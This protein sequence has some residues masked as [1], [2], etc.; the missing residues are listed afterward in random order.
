MNLSIG[1]IDT[2]IILSYLLLT[3]YIGVKQSRKIHNLRDYAIADKN[4]PLPVLVA[5][6]S[7]TLI[8]GGSTIGIVEKIYH[9]G[10][11]FMVILI[12][13]PIQKLI[14]AKYI[15]P[16]FQRFQ[17]MIS[18]G[19]IIGSK[20]GRSS[21]IITG[22]AGSLFMA[23]LLGGQMNA[24]GHVFSSLTGLS[25]IQSILIGSTIVL[26]YSTF[27][28][29]RAVTITDIFQFS[30]LIITVP[31]I[32]NIA[33]QDLGGYTA[34]FEKVPASHISWTPREGKL[35][36][37]MVTLIVMAIP[38]LA[39]DIVQRML[40]AKDTK[41]IS[42]T[43]KISA[44]ISVPFY[45]VVGMVGLIILAINPTL[46]PSEAFPYLIQYL[47]PVGIKGI[48]IAG[49]M[50]V[51][52]ST[53]DSI[54]NAASVVFVHDFLKPLKPKL[55]SKQELNYAK[56]AT[57]VIGCLAVGVAIKAK[58]I[59]D[60]VLGSLNLWGPVVVIPLYTAIFNL[61]VQKR[62]FILGALY[63][64]GTYG[65]WTFFQFEE[66]CGFDSLIPSML[67]NLLT[68]LWINWTPF[69][70]TSKGNLSKRI[71]KIL[72]DSQESIVRK[73]RM[74]WRP[75][76]R[77][78]NIP[79][80]TFSTFIVL[81]Y[82]VPYFMWSKSQ[83]SDLSL[84]F[85]FI[86]GCL[87]VFIMIRDY[88]PKPAQ[89]FFPFIWDS[90]LIFC[91]PYLAFFMLFDTHISTFWIVNVCLALFLLAQL[92]SWRMYIFSL[93]L[94]GSCAYLVH[95]SLGTPLVIEG[96]QLFLLVYIILFSTSIGIIFSRPREQAQAE[97]ENNLKALA[98]IIAHEMRTPLASIYHA[99][100]NLKPVWKKAL[101]S[102]S[103]TDKDSLPLSIQE[104]Q[105]KPEVIEKLAL[106]SQ[107]NIDLLLANIRSLKKLNHVDCFSVRQVVNDALKDYPQLPDIIINTH[108]KSDFHVLGNKRLLKQILFNLIKN[109]VDAMQKKGNIDITLGDTKDTHTLSIRDEGCGMQTFVSDLIFKKF[110][111]TKRHGTGL[112]LAFCKQ[113]M[114][115]M[116]GFITCHSERNQGTEFILHFP[117][118]SVQ[119]II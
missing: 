35:I 101:Q 39:P 19:D 105:E 85:R 80:L 51:I 87:C 46:A 94:G 117:K 41:Q 27:G 28:G 92:T 20:F 10:I 11:I 5:T 72:K 2:S 75:K 33:L 54:L 108:L 73:I 23:G 8:G 114:E 59:I 90:T 116:D 76:T 102:L 61:N 91:L 98:G 40:M 110:Y 1:V 63:G 86:A 56:V 6:L 21:Q 99:A 118:I 109:A 43:M 49:I 22:F 57:L 42:L 52:M 16:Q 104:Y 50:A 4:F 12:G 74:S 77:E 17:N 82:I 81:N 47:L 30:I 106:R 58:T 71:T 38:F 18:V 66:K 9:V 95:K 48:A 78:H 70:A 93:I 60:I 14:M 65:I 29:I 111:T 96:S 97:K 69:P 67:A 32:C 62:S 100:H 31:M 13:D 55:T 36:K 84:F 103:Q 88:W 89:R 119:T 83:H 15:A 113:A 45:I 3:L 107:A 26:I 24:M 7:A 112:G 79:Y 37:Y 64:V 25:Q 53:A 44:L 34:L 115:A 68:F